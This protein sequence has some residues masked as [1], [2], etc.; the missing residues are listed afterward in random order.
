MV[1]AL[2]LPIPLSAP[3]N[4]LPPGGVWQYDI[5][6]GTWSMA[7]HSGVSVSCS[8]IG[9]NVKFLLIHSILLGRCQSA[10]Q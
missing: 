8:I 10:R 4:V 9:M 6:S 5:G 3:P 2:A 1:A 7:G